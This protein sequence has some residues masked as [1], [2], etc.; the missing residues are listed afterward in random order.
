MLLPILMVLDDDSPLH[1]QVC[2]VLDL[3]C[4]PADRNGLDDGSALLTGGD[5]HLWRAPLP[6]ADED[7]PRLYADRTKRRDI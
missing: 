1:E 7:L 3:L 5:L 4:T 6:V 2:E